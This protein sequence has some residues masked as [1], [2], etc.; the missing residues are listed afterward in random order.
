[1]WIQ[2]RRIQLVHTA[3]RQLLLKS[4]GD[5]VAVDYNETIVGVQIPGRRAIDVNTSC[6]YTAPHSVYP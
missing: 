6:D 3:S 5:T 2:N 1:M 4:A